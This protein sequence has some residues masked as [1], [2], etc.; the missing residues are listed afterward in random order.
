MMKSI[1]VEL[2]ASIEVE[3]IIE[4]YET[5]QQGLGVAFQHRLRLAFRSIRRSP[6]AFGHDSV[7]GTRTFRIRRF[8]HI[9]HY[10]I[11]EP[12]IVVLAVAHPKRKPG[13]WLK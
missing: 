12:T 5:M 4:Y 10:L 3:G 1:V 6:E 8:P 9:V 7:T 2:R 11:E 13:Y